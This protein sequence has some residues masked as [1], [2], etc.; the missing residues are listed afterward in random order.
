MPQM[1]A[2]NV[3]NSALSYIDGGLRPNSLAKQTISLK[4]WC[5]S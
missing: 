1:C 2:K 4:I 3:N 5:W